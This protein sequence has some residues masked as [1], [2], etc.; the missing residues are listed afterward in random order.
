MVPPATLAMVRRPH[1]G[2][3][4]IAGIGL[5]ALLGALYVTS[6]GDEE[7][8]VAAE[9]AGPGTQV[10]KAALRI[11]DPGGVVEQL[12]SPAPA[13][14]SQVP[15]SNDRAPALPLATAEPILDSSPSSW[16]RNHEKT[17]KVR[18]LALAKDFKETVSDSEN[19]KQRSA[20]ARRS[21]AKPAAAAAPRPKAS[22]AKKTPVD[23]NESAEVDFGI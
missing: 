11:A 15:A 10:D 21:S 5:L 7:A 14:G 9:P 23:K 16:T 3:L 19:G 6:E 18:D 2:S 4:W 12:P 22:P 20:S 13:A 8:A 1:T 17:L